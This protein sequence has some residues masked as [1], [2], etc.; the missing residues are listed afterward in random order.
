MGKFVGEVSALLRKEFLLEWRQKYA[1]WS[2]LLYVTSTAYVCYLTFD[3]QPLGRSPLV[4]NALF[5]VILLFAAIN[6]VAKS[7]RQ[8]SE[9]RFYFYYATCS[10]QAIILAKMVYNAALMLFVT[11]AGFAVYATVVGMPGGGVDVGLFVGNLAFG[12]LGFSTTLT[13][14][15]AIAAKSGGNATL[16]AV[17]SFP[18]ILPLLVL[19]VRVSKHALDGLDRSLIY[20]ELLTLL[21]VDALIATAALLLFPY[22]WRSV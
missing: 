2:V 17:L 10:P 8:E 18:V 7:F 6:T 3:M 5:W 12:A 4:W 14:V 9:A 11:L 22:L 21:A 16:M 15:S 13:L 20:D 19:L 1:L